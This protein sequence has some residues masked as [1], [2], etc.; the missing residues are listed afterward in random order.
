MAAMKNMMEKMADEGLTSYI[1]TFEIEG[2]ADQ[3][4]WEQYWAS[5][6]DHAGAQCED[7][8]GFD[9]RYIH[10]IETQAEYE[11]RTGVVLDYGRKETV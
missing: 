4:M 5:N 10:L 7:S 9:L 11:N 6:I 3:L 1:V 2:E 8:V